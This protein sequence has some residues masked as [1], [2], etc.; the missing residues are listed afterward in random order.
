MARECA[1]PPPVYLTFAGCSVRRA[2][3]L[4]G[5]NI[6]A[7]GDVSYLAAP[8]VLTTGR[9]GCRGNLRPSAPPRRPIRAYVVAPANA[10]TVVNLFARSGKIGCAGQI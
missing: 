4:P 8:N 6:L 7:R 5:S 2:C 10:L 1:D 9:I 3:I